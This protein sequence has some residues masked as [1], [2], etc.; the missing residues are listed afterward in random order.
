MTA[1]YANKATG[2][3]GSDGWNPV[4]HIKQVSESMRVVIPVNT[5]AERDALSTLFPGGIIPVGTT[6]CRLDRKASLEPWNGSAWVPGPL[7][8]LASVTSA[9]INTVSKP[10]SPNP[11][12][13]TPTL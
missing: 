3:V 12:W 1:Q 2:P 7:G 10:A 9:G 11:A 8:Q 4:A 13:L 6:A 5:K